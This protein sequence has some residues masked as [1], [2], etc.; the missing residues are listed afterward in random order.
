MATVCAKLLQ[1]CLTPCDPLD[2]D[3]S[4]PVSSLQGILQ[5][6]TLGCH[7]FLQKWP[8]YT[9]LINKTRKYGYKAPYFK[10]FVYC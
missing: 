10:E 7:A 1:S 2:A 5:A 6:R 8:L 3:S 4:L 9:H